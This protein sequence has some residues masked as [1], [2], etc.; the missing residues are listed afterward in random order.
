MRMKLPNFMKRSSISLRSLVLSVLSIATLL[1]ALAGCQAV[2]PTLGNEYIPKDHIMRIRRDSSFVVKTYNVTVDSV[3]TSMEVMNLLGSYKNPTTG[4]A[5]DAGIVFQMEAAY[6]FKQRDSLYGTRP[7]IDSARMRFTVYDAVGKWDTE[8]IFDLYELDKR[9]YLDSTYY[10]DFDPSPYMPARPLAS[11]I[12]SGKGNI[13]MRIEDEAFLS[14]LL[15]TTGYYQDSL[16]KRRFKSFYIKPR[17]AGEDAAL[18]RI[19]MATYS[20]LT[21]Y[22]HNAEYPDTVLMTT[23]NISPYIAEI[24][25]YTP[26]NQ[27]INVISRDYSDVRG[28]LHLDDP[29]APVS[30]IFVESFG[31]IATRLEF[32]KESVEALRDKVRQAGFRD[33][34]INKAV[35]QMFYPVRDP[36]ERDRLPGRLG[37]YT[38]FS[39]RAGIRDYSWYAEYSASLNPYGA[40]QKL[41]YDGTI[42]PARYLYQMDVTEYFQELLKEEGEPSAVYLAPSYETAY[43]QGQDNWSNPYTTELSGYGSPTPPLLVVTYTMIR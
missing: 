39:K 25:S 10:L 20:Q 11:G 29:T 22:Y 35:L 15:D 2:D 21:T 7:V 12:H 5:V 28:E 16:F 38:D 40:Q 30:R 18:Y 33:L 32:T 36:D 31:G 14:R 6:L 43:V 27:T 41:N 37:M 17:T 26:A 1:A 23:Y 19:D 24:S 3:A 13:V 8:Q 42:K 4:E 34:V 9:L